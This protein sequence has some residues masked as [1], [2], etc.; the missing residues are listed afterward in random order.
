MKYEQEKILLQN[1]D[2]SPVNVQLE[3]TEACNLRCRFCYNSQQPV[4]CSKY[5]DI[6]DRLANEKVMEIVLTGGE[7]MLHPDFVKIVE[8]CSNKFTKVQIQT[9]GTHITREMAKTLEAF[10]VQ[11]VNV[12]LHGFEETND[13]L[14][15]VKGSYKKA[16][17]GIKAILSTNVMVVSNFVLTSKNIS[18]LPAHIDCLC[19]IGV[20]N[21]TLTRFS[22]TGVGSSS[23]FLKTSKDELLLALEYVNNKQRKE[24]GVSFLL[25]NSIPRCALPPHLYNHCNYCHFGA[26]RFYIDVKGNVLV[27]GMSRVKL[28]NLLEDSI[29]SIKEKSQIYKNHITGESFP[30][31][32]KVCADFCLCRGGCRAAAMSVSGSFSGADPLSV[33]VN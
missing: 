9:N 5:N 32:C 1:L 14:T 18:E 22:P 33:H 31:K 21:F 7:P 30:Q 3:L 13:Y 23:T 27:C 15:R 17:D 28:G 26:S 29:R 11:S 24:K 4:L 19:N 20:K 16:L 8:I 2:V 6:I 10:H 12:S 25:A